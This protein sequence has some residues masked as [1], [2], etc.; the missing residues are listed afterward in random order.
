VG[1]NS[2]PAWRGPGEG[3]G[4]MRPSRGDLLEALAWAIFAGAAFALTYRFDAPLPGYKFGA[5]GWPR[6]IIIATGVS[7]LALLLSA[8]LSRPP[9]RGGSGDRHAPPRSLAAE[10]DPSLGRALGSL[11]RARWRTVLGRFAT[12]A[13]PLAYVFVMGR[14]GFLLTTPFFLAAYMYLVG[15]RRPFTLVWVTT[16]IYALVVVI[17]VKALYTPLPQGVGVFHSLNGQLINLIR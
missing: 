16:A 7:A 13:V 12:F 2:T 11:L 4:T 14:V 15:I 10:G 8:V 6:A 9:G 3:Q 5:V 1:V 17:F